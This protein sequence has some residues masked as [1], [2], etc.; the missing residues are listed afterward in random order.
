MRVQSSQSDVENVL[1]SDTPAV[2][3]HV[4]AEVKLGNFPAD[5]ADRPLTRVHLKLS[6]LS[7]DND[8]AA[9]L[10]SHKARDWTEMAASTHDKRS[11]YLAVDNP[12]IV[13]SL[14]AR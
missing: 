14:Q 8:F 4:R 5:G 2:A 13:G 3:S 11:L 7:G 10:R 6:L 12:A 9:D 1:L